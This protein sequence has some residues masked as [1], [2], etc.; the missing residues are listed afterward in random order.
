MKR[1]LGFLARTLPKPM[2]RDVAKEYKPL[3]SWIGVSLR[4]EKLNGKCLVEKDADLINRNLMRILYVLLANYA[5]S[6][7]P[8][9]TLIDTSNTSRTGYLYGSSSSTYPKYTLGTYEQGGLNDDATGILIGSGTT[10][11]T[12]TD[13]NLESQ[14]TNSQITHQQQTY[15]ELND[16]EF[17]LNREFTDAQA[18]LSVTEAG[19]IY[20]VYISG[21]RYSFLLV[22]DTFS[23]ISV[24]TGNGIR[25]RYTFSF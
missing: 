21:D 5:D 22:R 25:V 10:S 18:D 2:I 16:Y 14:I 7:G 4:V 6:S 19:I 23:A 13:Y 9:I 3:H 20:E 24:T 1:I 11:P 15:E 12:R 8:E 17:R